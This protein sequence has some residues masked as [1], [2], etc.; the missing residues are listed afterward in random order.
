METIMYRKVEAHPCMQELHASGCTSSIPGTPDAVR[1]T[2]PLPLD[3]FFPA[4]SEEEMVTWTH[5][6]PTALV[7]DCTQE[8]SYWEMVSTLRKLN[9]P[10]EVLEELNWSWK[11]EL[12]DTYEV[13]T[14]VRLDS[15]D[16]LLLGRSGE[17]R[18]RI[19]LWGESLRPQEEI[20]VLVQKSLAIRARA[21][22]WQTWLALGG[23][24]FGFALGLWLGHLSPD[25]KPL[26]T[27][28]MFAL[29]GV[30]F[31]CLPM[32]LY[33]PENRQHDFLDC[34]RS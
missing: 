16:P 4:V 3:L 15:R 5:W 9:A 23:G 24:L 11:M 14:P 7:F 21:A 2:G 12:F 17:Q 26:I 27:G 1:E 29:L 33:T 28:F 10:P 8:L 31:G 20:T 13:R 6:L 30:F 19:A 34:Y 18:Y 22:Q 32:L 25:S